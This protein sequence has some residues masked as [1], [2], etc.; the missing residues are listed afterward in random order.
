LPPCRPR[1]W[2]SCWCSGT[3]CSGTRCE[4]A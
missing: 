1:C 2:W 3:R 4:R